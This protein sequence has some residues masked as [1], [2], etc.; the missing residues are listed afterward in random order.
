M[1]ALPAPTA[2]FLLLNKPKTEQTKRDARDWN[3]RE[4]CYPGK[5]RA[6]KDT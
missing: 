2:F 6:E 1:R 5:Q 4:H 3:C